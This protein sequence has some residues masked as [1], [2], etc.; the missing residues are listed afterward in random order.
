MVV[1]VRANALNLDVS[2]PAEQSEGNDPAVTAG[3]P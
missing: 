1:I 3:R 2:F